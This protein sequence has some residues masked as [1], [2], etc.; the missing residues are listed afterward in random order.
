MHSARKDALAC[1]GW[2]LLAVLWLYAR[3]AHGEEPERRRVVLLEQGRDS[4]MERVG[5]EIEKLGF[6]VVRSAEGS[7][8]AAARAE[9][10]QVAIRVLAARNGVE[11]WMPD[12]TS[13]RS[14]LRQVIVDENP[15]GPDRDVIALQTAELLRTSLL[16]EKTAPPEM[17]TAPQRA[18]ERAVEGKSP[19]PEPSHRATS[20]QV[21]GGVLYSPGGVG[22]TAELGLSLQHFW[23]QLW[24]VAADLAVPVRPGTIRDVEGSA[25]IG[26]YF[27]GLA[28][29]AR[30]VPEGRRFFA[31]AGLGL[32]LL[33]VHYD[34]DARL[35][36]RSSSGVHWTG[37][38]CLRADLG[39]RVASWLKLGVRG[40]AGV[41]VQR[42]SITFAG[43]D[44]GS[45]G[46]F[47][48]TSLA[49][50]EVPLR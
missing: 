4:F 46:P 21:T 11:I 9:R 50:A 34:G 39:V 48:F 13:G 1:I 22:A 36:L 42:V 28:A 8:E 25:K 29:L 27:A 10:A 19:Q 38:P 7:L 33:V 24:G 23:G 35:P 16:G 2:M 40:L 41:T 26:T 3:P 44:A 14:L 37:G 43:N 17:Q 18:P 49:L 5:A 12:V 6:I 20:I 31:S 30:L 32:A 47:F 15:R 45:I